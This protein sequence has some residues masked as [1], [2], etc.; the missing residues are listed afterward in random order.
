MSI[1]GWCRNLLSA[2]LLTSDFEIVSI[3]TYSEIHT[4]QHVNIPTLFFHKALCPLFATF[5]QK[6]LILNS[7]ATVRFQISKKKKVVLLC[8]CVIFLFFYLHL[9]FL[10]FFFKP[11]LKNLNFV[12]MFSVCNYLTGSAPFILF[13]FFFM[14]HSCVSKTIT[15][16]NQ[17]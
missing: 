16:C 1:G 11:S 12:K 17:L 6:Y 4:Y 3:C 15:L 10:S 7:S 13:L 5:F 2:W 8:V 9:F 14:L